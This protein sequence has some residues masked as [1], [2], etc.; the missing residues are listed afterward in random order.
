MVPDLK[1]DILTKKALIEALNQNTYWNKGWIVM[2][3]SKVYWLATNKNI[4]D[5][6]ICAIV[7]TQ[8]GQIISYVLT[9]PDTIQLKDG[10]KHQVNWLREWWVAPP[11]EGTVVASFVFNKALKKL[12]NNLLIES[13]AAKVEDFLK[14]QFKTIYSK[15]RH[16]LFL[17]LHK[18]VLASKLSFAKY[19]GVPIAVANATIVK[20]INRLNY[21][22][23]QNQ[24]K[25][26]HYEYVNQLDD[27]TWQFV[28]DRC[29]QDFSI[30]S[31]NYINWLLDNKQYVQTPIAHRFPFKF[32]TT[33]FSKNI[34]N[35]SFKIVK[36][37]ETIGFISY[38]HNMIEFNVRFFITKDDAHYP[39]VLAALMEHALQSGATYIITDDVQLNHEIN[40]TYK[41]LFTY[42]QVKTAKAH[43]RM[44]L[45]FEDILLTDRDGRFH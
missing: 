14:P 31:K 15:T 37:Q 4:A 16:T 28:K 35:H 32:S 38:L 45:N 13:N 23:T 24:L 7:C 39:I 12:K 9:L 20:L 29:E 21:N 8:N 19:L 18:D 11:F 2:P 34:H 36:D 40:T 26:L 30:K 17:K 6:A 22:K 25:G 3:K 42:K 33:G 27:T 5:E 1:V 44:E 10:T 43:K 41:T